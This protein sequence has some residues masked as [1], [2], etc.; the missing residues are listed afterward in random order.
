MYEYMKKFSLLIF[1]GNLFFS[2]LNSEPF[3]GHNLVYII[4]DIEIFSKSVKLFFLLLAG[5]KFTFLFLG[6]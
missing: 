6:F 3:I 4:L 5:P 2:Y 1:C